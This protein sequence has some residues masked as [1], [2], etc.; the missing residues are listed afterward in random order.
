MHEEILIYH[1]LKQVW[2][3]GHIQVKIQRCGVG[4]CPGRVTIPF[5][6]N[7]R[8]R[9]HMCI[10]GYYKD[11]QNELTYDFLGHTFEEAF[12]RMDFAKLLIQMFR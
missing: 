5:L 6:K 9:K 11:S 3:L 10:V 4:E 8:P 12:R 1:R 7:H 2:G